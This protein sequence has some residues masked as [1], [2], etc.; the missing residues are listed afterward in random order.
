MKYISTLI[1]ALFIAQFAFSQ[2]QEKCAKIAETVFEAI[3]Q[4]DFETI[5][6]YL[7]KDFTIG[8]QQ[9]PIAEMVLKQLIN[10]LDLQKYTAT[11]TTSNAS[12]LTLNYDVEYKGLTAKKALFVFNADNKIEKLELLK[13]EVK[14]LKRDDVSI[15]YNPAKLIEI[16]F[17]EMGKLI[18]V[19]AKINGT[20][21]NFILDSGSPTTIINSKYANKKDVK[22]ISTAKGAT[23]NNISGM[24]IQKYSI[25]FYGIKTNAQK[26]LV[27]DISGLE[28]DSMKIYGLIGYDFI[29]EYDVLFDYKEK[30]IKL[31]KP[32]Y[33][34]TYKKERLKQHSIKTIPLILRGHIPIITAEIAKK[35]YR[36]GIDCGATVNTLDKKYYLDIKAYLRKEEVDSLTGISKEK[37]IIKTAVL[38]K[39]YIDKTLYKRTNLALMDMAHLNKNAKITI[40]GL[41]GYEFLSKQ[42]TLLS[43]KR[44]EI[45]LIR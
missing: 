35:K 45:L 40:D 37:K 22:S 34:E 25:D 16:P 29:K 42:G 9:T 4:K 24:D 36:M 1:L 44:K 38:K 18:V 19:E 12:G 30:I 15:Q 17:I 26:A 2:N 32:S 11:N 20:K 39:L 14:N 23:G 13:I 43:Y 8:G 10:Q 3:I 31:I 41:L 33:F 28:K 6:P 21:R 7:T 27:A 5:K